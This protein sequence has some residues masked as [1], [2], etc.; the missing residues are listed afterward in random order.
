MANCKLISLMLTFVFNYF[1][2]EGGEL[3]RT[4]KQTTGKTPANKQKVEKSLY[5][6]S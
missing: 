5:M 3:P 4:K 2:K 1:K 6:L